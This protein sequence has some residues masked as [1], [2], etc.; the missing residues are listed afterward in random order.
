MADYYVEGGDALKNKLKITDPEL[1]RQVEED[2]FSDVA[3]DIVNEF[4][5]NKTFDFEF[6]KTLHGK[7]FGKVYYFAG[8][9]RTVNITK[10]NSSIPF[11]YADFIEQEAERIFSDLKSKNYL[12]GMPKKV[13]VEEIAELAMNL[14]ALHPFREGNGRTSRLFLQLLAYNA[15]YLLDYSLVTHNEI[16]E[17]DRRAFLGDDSLL[18]AMYEKIVD[19]I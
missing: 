8:K 2:C 7:L 17:A 6:L 19:T 11:C 9:V 15:G 12:E 18:K 13:F 4:V 14:N 16:V 3:A 10:Q 5:R 1:L